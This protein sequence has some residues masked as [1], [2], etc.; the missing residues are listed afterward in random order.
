MHAAA[1]SLVGCDTGANV[2]KSKEEEANQLEKELEQQAA[3][4]TMVA[5]Q[6]ETD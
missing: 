2:N 1:Q 4:D 6:C 3:A 5:M